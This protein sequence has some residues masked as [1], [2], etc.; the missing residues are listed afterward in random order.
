MEY[1][2]LYLFILITAILGLIFALL[3]AVW[4]GFLCFF[5][6]T[7]V[8][9]AFTFCY[10]QHTKYKELK[11]RIYQKRYEDAYLYADANGQ[12]LDVAH[13]KYPRKQEAE[14]RGL[15]RDG[16]IGYFSSILFCIFSSVVLIMVFIN[17]F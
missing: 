13:F 5:G 9:S 7:L 12:K 16:A 6:F 8:L 2:K 17:I 1:K 4:I 3:S 10:I 15:I 11:E 14:F